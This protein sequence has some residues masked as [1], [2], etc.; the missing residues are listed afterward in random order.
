MVGTLRQ[1]R[2]VGAG[3][4]FKVKAGSDVPARCTVSIWCSTKRFSGFEKPIDSVLEHAAQGVHQAVRLDT[5]SYALD[6]P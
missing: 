4:V 5:S 3:L 1:L 2:W 6:L